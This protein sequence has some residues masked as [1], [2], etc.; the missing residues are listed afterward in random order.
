VRGKRQGRPKRWVSASMQATFDIFRPGV[1]FEIWNKWKRKK[2]NTK[3]GTL[4]V[5]V[6]GLRWR[7]GR[8]GKGSVRQ[9]SWDKVAGWFD[10]P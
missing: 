10:K 4:T 2:K 1:T 6:G 8:A 3:L 9:L 7:H 5:S